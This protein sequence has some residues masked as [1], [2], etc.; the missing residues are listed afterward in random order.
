MEKLEFIAPAYSYNKL[1]GGTYDKIRKF[2]EQ[3]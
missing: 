3:E 2:N 1:V